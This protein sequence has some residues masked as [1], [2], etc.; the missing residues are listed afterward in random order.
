MQ[1]VLAAE[2]VDAGDAGEQLEAQR[3]VVAQ[4]SGDQTGCAPRST[5]SVSS[6]RSTTILVI[7]ASN[8]G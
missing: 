8:S 7:A 4:R 3:G 2:V 6:P 5:Y 1:P